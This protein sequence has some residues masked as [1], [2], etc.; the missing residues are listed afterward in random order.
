[1]MIVK[2]EK[3]NM[4]EFRSCIATMLQ[5]GETKDCKKRLTSRA[6]KALPFKTIQNGAFGI[7]FRITDRF[8]S[9]DFG[10]KNT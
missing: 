8:F 2:S 10:R 3:K 4:S 5:R 1:M 9:I 6:V 7:T